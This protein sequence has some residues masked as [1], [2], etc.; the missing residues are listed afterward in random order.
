MSIQ[1][2]IAINIRFS[3]SE[4]R[5]LDGVDDLKGLKMRAPEGPI[6]NVFA[7]FGA[8]VCAGGSLGTMIPMPY[9]SHG[10]VALG[11]DSP[12]LTLDLEASLPDDN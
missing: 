8:V 12:R 10:N 3:V 5:S 6:A 7:A 9:P 4:I 2:A 1:T 11:L